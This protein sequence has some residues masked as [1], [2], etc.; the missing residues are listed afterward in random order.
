VTTLGDAR[1]A[2]AA[3]L[4]GVGVPV[5]DQAPQTLTAPCVVLYP[6]SPWR[7]PRGHVGFDITLY[8]NPAG[9]NASALTRLEELADAVFTALHSAGV[10]PGEVARPTPETDGGVLATSIP[11]VLRMK[12]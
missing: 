6:G 9:G 7:D 11:V 10:A 5:H 3:A 2:L 1:L 8:A 12:P 4:S